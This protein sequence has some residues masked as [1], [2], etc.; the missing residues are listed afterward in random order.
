MDVNYWPVPGANTGCISTIGS[1]FKDPS[2]E[3]LVTDDRGYP[4]WKA[5]TNP[6]GNS[7]SQYIESIAVPPEQALRGGN[8]N[9]LSVAPTIQ[10]REY[11]RNNVT[12]AMN[13]SNPEIVATIGNFR[14]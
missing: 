6:W 5:Q 10:A 1:I 8:M 7:G 14:W 2:T 9:P 3:L 11:R 4:Y 12:R 13:M